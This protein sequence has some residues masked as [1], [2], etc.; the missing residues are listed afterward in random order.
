MFF[1]LALYMQNILGYSPLEAGVRFLPT[2]LMVMTVAPIAGRLSDRI[3]PRWP[4][5]AGLSVTTTSLFMFTQ[6]GPGTTYA[7]LLPA[8]IL[9]GGGVALTMSPMSTA[10]MNA[11]STAKAGIASGI[12][13]MFRMVGGTFGVA[14]IGAIFQ[15]E[16]G[17][18][19]APSRD[20]FI[21]A[22]SHAMW[23]STAVAAAGVVIAFTLIESRKEH[24]P[25]VE[26]E[27]AESAGTPLAEIATVQADG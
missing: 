3:G 6:I 24:A 26:E 21:H 16:A 15:A 13:S 19:I 18:V 5:V 9:M 2:T 8:F 27:L 14:A 11:V 23:L 1:F 12:L 20:G 7:S 25:P 10:A 4:I 22:L 17:S